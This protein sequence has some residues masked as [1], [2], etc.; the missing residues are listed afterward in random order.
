MRNLLLI[1]L[2]STSLFGQI[3]ATTSD[4]KDVMLSKDGTWKYVEQKEVSL[5]DMGIWEVSYFVDDFGDPT[6]SGYITTIDLVE[7]KFSNSATTNAKLY[8][9]FI[10][11]ENKISIKMAEYGSNIV[12]GSSSYP[13]NYVIIFKHNGVKAEG[14][15][16]ATNRSDRL[17][18]D[19]KKNTKK[20]LDKLIEGGSFSF[21]IGDV[22]EYTSARYSFK[23]QADGFSNAYR[24]LFP[25]S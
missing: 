10:I 21:V 3:K 16:T 7:G 1:L 5:D 17:V 19:G 22:S 20:L 8:V 18:I 9:I 11:T 14:R 25:S 4:G 2:F 13:D 12:K 15:Y 24:T 23:I 6:D